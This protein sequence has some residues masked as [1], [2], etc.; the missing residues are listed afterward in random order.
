MAVNLRHCHFLAA[1]GGTADFVVASGFAGRHKPSEAD[2]EDALTYGYIARSEDGNEWELGEG[3]YTAGPPER[4]SR[5]EVSASS[6][7]GGGK[8]AFTAPPNVVVNNATNV[9][10]VTP[11]VFAAY[12]EQVNAA[13][14]ELDG[15]VA[16]AI[17]ALQ[18]LVDGL[19]S[20][21]TALQ[22]DFGSRMSA[23]EDRLDA[24]EALNIPIY[25]STQYVFTSATVTIPAHA[26]RARVRMVGSG[27]GYR[28]FVG[29]CGAALEKLL[30][31]LTPGLTLA[32]TVSN[33]HAGYEV[34]GIDTVLASG[35]QSIATLT[36]G[37]GGVGWGS[38]PSAGT[39]SGGDLNINGYGAYPAWLSGYY[40]TGGLPG[41][42]ARS[43][44]PGLIM[45]DWYADWASG[46]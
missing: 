6:A 20:D 35:T 38:P 42:P 24:L 1:A 14:G 41:D 4:L 36:A 40:G 29:G 17:A 22:G 11:A 23:A 32:A 44:D 5:V 26:N 34:A 30:T 3:V 45:I 16:E 7:D 46:L 2:A 43:G 31:G 28:T 10:R 27:G 15:S 25:L 19:R 33:A 18:S 39:A 13:L 21:L 12:Q 37:G 8:V 9:P